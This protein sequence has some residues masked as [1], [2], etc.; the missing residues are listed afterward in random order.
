LAKLGDF[1]GS[2]KGPSRL[3]HLLRIVFLT[4]SWGMRNALALALTFDKTG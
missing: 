1:G 3:D 4:R 2:L